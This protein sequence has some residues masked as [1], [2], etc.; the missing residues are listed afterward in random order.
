M[1]FAKE[2]KGMTLNHL[3]GSPT[4]VGF[5]VAEAWHEDEHII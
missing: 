5:E 3:N 2:Y 1:R 4:L